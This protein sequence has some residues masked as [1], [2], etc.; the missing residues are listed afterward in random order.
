MPKSINVLNQDFFKKRHEPL[1]LNL[2]FFAEGD[3]PNDPPAD[4]PA[5][6]PEKLELTQE[7]LDKKV[8][9]ES[10]RKTQ[11]ALEK[12]KKEMRKEL[13]KEVKAQKEEAERL[14]KLSQK[15]REDAELK[16]R[17]DALD[18]REQE[19]GKKE[20]KAQ[21]IT[22]LNEKKL[23]SSFADFLL[24]EDGKKTFENIGNFKKT[25]DEAIENKVNE[26]LKGDPPK[27]GNTQGGEITKEQFN[28]MGYLE[29][30]KLFTEK[31]DLYNKLIK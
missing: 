2:Q 3:P 12:Q 29:R 18:A 1:R 9:S 17:Q 4:P 14:A 6:P 27:V 19:L 8:E 15:E 16:K 20:L 5:D 31:P 22:E 21:A 23:P 30:E 24:A 11:S 10:D 26:R 7:E 28:E 25:F 13:E